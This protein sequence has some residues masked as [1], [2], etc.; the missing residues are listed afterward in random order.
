MRKLALLLVLVCM[1][2]PAFSTRA[3]GQPLNVYFA[4]PDGGVRTA[5]GLD[6]DVHF[7][8]DPAAADV[9]VLNG[10]IPGADAATIRTRV[11]G[12]AGLIL[13]LGP[14]QAGTVTTDVADAA[15]LLERFRT[16]DDAHAHLA[17]HQQAEVVA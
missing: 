12:G 14:E 9:F 5:L 11:Q 10:Q 13:L 6:K 16:S 17:A 15:G 7:T 1:F 8:A 2:I 4:G 3:A